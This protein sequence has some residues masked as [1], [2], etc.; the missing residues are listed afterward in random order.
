[1]LRRICSRNTDAKYV[2]NDIRSFKGDARQ[3]VSELVTIIKRAYSEFDQ[4]DPSSNFSVQVRHCNQVFEK[5][6]YDPHAI[7]SK[8]LSQYQVLAVLSVI[9]GQ[10]PHRESVA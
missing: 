8:A 10:K 9:W 7:V 5:A 2:N 6:I 1:M 3:A 4:H